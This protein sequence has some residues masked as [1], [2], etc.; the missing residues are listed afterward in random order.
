MASIIPTGMIIGAKIVL[1]VSAK[2]SKKIR[3]M[4]SKESISEAA[5]HQPAHV[6]L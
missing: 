1:P 5:Y 4:P 3:I 2:A 6:A